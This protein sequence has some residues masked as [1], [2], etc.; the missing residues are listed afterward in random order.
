[1]A[2]IVII[3]GGVAGLTAGIYA[4]MNGFEAV[5]YEKHTI[6]GGNLTGWNRGG[7]HIDNCVHWLTGTN[8]VTEHYR[9]W[10]D[11]G[12]LGDVDIHQA[13]VLYTFEKNGVS[14]SLSRDVSRLHRDMLTLSPRDMKQIDSF[15]KALN[16]A[17]TIIGVS[18]KR[19]DRKCSAPEL[20]T[21]LP[22]LMRYHQMTTHELSL[23]FHH[24]VIRGFIRC[25]FP[26]DFGAMGLLVALATFCSDNGG[27]PAGGSL[28]MAQRMAQ[29]FRALGGE[30]H[31]GR[32]VTQIRTHGIRAVSVVLDDDSVVPADEVIL[33]VDPKIAFGSMLDSSYMPESLKKLY[34][35][36]SVS[37]F[38]S[39]HCAFA[40]D[41]P[42]LPFRGDRIIE[43]PSDL[44][45]ELRYRYLILREY[46]HEGKFAPEGKSLL[47]TMYYCSQEECRHIIGLK[48]NAG[49]YRRYKD[50]I[51][52]SVLDTITIH[53]PELRDH[54]RCIDTWTP[55]TY[56]RYTGADVGS[57]MGFV[58]PPKL[59]P[60]FMSGKI[61]GLDNVQLATQWQQAPGGLPV[62]AKAGRDAIKEIVKRNKLPRCNH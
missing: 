46:S 27:I 48:K 43:I 30:L 51:A 17:K 10:T 45:E 22:I 6:P 58:F 42:A 1:M 52:Q 49:S 57:Y 47:Q 29:R 24:P 50:N 11:T 15:I 53:F 54:L 21:S 44:P 26:K 14:L 38:S 62:A 59:N 36:P 25:L 56:R 4:R 2:K 13:D 55:A 61:R 31:C 18:A 12:A 39:F 41:L 34:D 5:I 37:R 20:L 19:N 3:G 7:Y 35:D 8:P 32:S 16:A 9:I 40:C 33:T 28:A 60:M 23:R